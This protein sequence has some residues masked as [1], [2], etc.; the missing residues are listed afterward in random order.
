[1]KKAPLFAHRPPSVGVHLLSDPFPEHLLPPPSL[2]SGN[3]HDATSKRVVKTGA[4]RK[5]S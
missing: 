5:T 2:R 1:M 4:V 3:A